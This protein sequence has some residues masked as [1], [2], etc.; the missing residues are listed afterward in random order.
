MIGLRPRSDKVVPLM[1]ASAISGQDA[2]LYLDQR[3]TGMAE[4]QVNFE[5]TAL[6]EA[7]I[8]LPR[9]EEQTAIAEELSDMDAELAA[10][11][12]RRDKTRPVKQAMM[13]ELL[14]GRTRLV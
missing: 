9:L 8:R 12:A 6:L 7:P 10:L 4:S 11:E 1:L 14:T 13:Q 3:T 2:Q 5:N